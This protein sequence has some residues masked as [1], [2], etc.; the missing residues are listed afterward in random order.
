MGGIIVGYELG[1]ILNKQ[2]IF[3]EV[4][5]EFKL[6]RDFKIKGY[7]SFNMKM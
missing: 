5:S 2:T 3:A 1:K 4:N 7:K 6:R